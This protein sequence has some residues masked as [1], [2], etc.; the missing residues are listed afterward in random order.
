[1]SEAERAAR[2][3]GEAAALSSPPSPP[4]ALPLLLPPLPLLPLSR[5]R[6]WTIR[7]GE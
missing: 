5:S 6:G 7:S 4:S 2:R 3:E 1:M